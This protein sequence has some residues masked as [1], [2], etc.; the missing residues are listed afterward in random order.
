[1]RRIALVAVLALMIFSAVVL[2]GCSTQPAPQS[3]T[4]VVS[5]DF[6]AQDPCQRTVFKLQPKPGVDLAQSGSRLLGAY[7]GYE[8][9]GVVALNTLDGTLDVTWCNAMQSEQGV[10]R[11]VNLSGL[12]AIQEFATTPAN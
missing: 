2:A 3:A 12:V 11:A 7:E 5:R 4:G 6:G 1:M 10:V 9:I 8:A